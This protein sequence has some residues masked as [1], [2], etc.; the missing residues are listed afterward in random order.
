[1]SQL[2]VLRRLPGGSVLSLRI[3]SQLTDDSLQSFERIPLGGYQSVRGYRQNQLLK[4][5]GWDAMLD[6]QIPVLEQLQDR[7]YTLTLIPH[8]GFARGW[9]SERF[10]NIDRAA[11]LSSAGVSLTIASDSNWSA[12]LDWAHRFESKRKQGDELQD[13]G[14][15]LSLNYGF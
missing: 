3:N 12:R 2:E 6:Y 5:N 9:D 14:I 1:M 11:S 10:S 8:I 7:G 4:D 15:Y 13:D